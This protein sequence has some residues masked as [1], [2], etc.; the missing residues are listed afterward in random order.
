MQNTIKTFFTSAFTKI[1]SNYI[2][3]NK[4]M[5]YIMTYSTA[6]SSAYIG[7]AYIWIK[8]SNQHNRLQ[9]KL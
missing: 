9:R 6:F 1:K 2:E 5:F 7:S 4:D 3:P 8:L